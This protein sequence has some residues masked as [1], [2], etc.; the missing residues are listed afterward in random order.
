MGVGEGKGRV[1][2]LF[3]ATQLGRLLSGEGSAKERTEPR[4]RCRRSPLAHLALTTNPS[5]TPQISDTPGHAAEDTGSGVGPKVSRGKA[6]DSAF[7][8]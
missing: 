4:P 3:R 8:C 2:M 5:F 7:H 1:E 6:R